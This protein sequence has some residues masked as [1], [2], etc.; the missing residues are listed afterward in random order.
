MCNTSRIRATQ[1]EYIIKQ[2]RWNHTVANV[3]L[4]TSD[5]AQLHTGVGLPLMEIT[6][7]TIKYAGHS[8]ILS[9]RDQLTHIGGSLWIEEVWSAPLQHEHD[10]FI[11]DRFLRIPGI[12]T[13]QLHRA[14]A[15]RLYLRV[16]TIADLAHPSGTFIPDGNLSGDWQG[17]SDLHWPLQLKPPPLFWA[18][19]RPCIWRS[20]CTTAASH[21]P[22]HYGMDLDI[23]LGKWLPVVRHS[24]FEVYK[25]PLALYWR[26]DSSLYL[27]K[28]TT[29]S[30]FYII[31]QE[32]DTL[33]LDSHPIG[34]RDVGDS[35]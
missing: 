5:S 30:G 6:T 22:I 18:E 11:M 15:V 28:S 3:L 33:P 1:V 14:N 20:F 35:I 2:L 19:F 21:Q 24:W 10:E 29:V 34:F 16:L 4:T 23:H 13:A 8:F 31:A 17:G 32:V 9:L 7:P 25:S 27:L 12:T 26:I